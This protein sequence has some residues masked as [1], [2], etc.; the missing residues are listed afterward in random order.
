M[1]WANIPPLH[2]TSSSCH[3]TSQL[4]CHVV[5]GS[6]AERLPQCPRTPP[7]TAYAPIRYAR[8]SPK[9]DG[10]TQGLAAPERTPDGPTFKAAKWLQTSPDRDSQETGLLVPPAPRGNAFFFLMKQSLD[11]W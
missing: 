6:P 7:R 11:T 4:V 1:C 2:C 8:D 9:Q 3:R 10:S 5:P